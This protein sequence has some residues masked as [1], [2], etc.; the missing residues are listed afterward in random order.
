MKKRLA[1]LALIAL[2]LLSA[3]AAPQAAPAPA[4]ENMISFYYC[5][6]ELQ[7]G[8]QSGTISSEL[9]TIADE[10]DFAAWL[11]VYLRGPLSGELTTP[12]P[13]AVNVESVSL[14]GACATVVLSAEYGALVGIERTLANACLT[15]T[16]TQL[17]GVESVRIEVVDDAVGAPEVTAYTASDFAEFDY[18]SNAEEVT[19]RLY[20]SDRAHRYLLSTTAQVAAGFGDHLPD[21]IVSRLIAGPSDDAMRSVMPEGTQLLGCTIADGV[22]T[23]DFNQ[24]FYDNRPTAESVERVLIYSIVNSV[25]GLSGIHTVRFEIEG[26]PAGM[27]RYL[28]LSLAYT[29]NENAVG[30]VR[31]AAG[32]FD[33]TLY[34]CG[35]DSAH[36]SAVPLRVRCDEGQSQEEA[37]MLALLTIQ[38]PTGLSSPIPA[39]TQLRS[40][41]TADGLCQVDLSEEFRSVQSAAATHA[42]VLA[43]T[44]LPG[45]E[46]VQLLVEGE[47]R[48]SVLT[49]DS[50]WRYPES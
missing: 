28:D 31:E 47:T 27:Y 36:L 50:A 38:P 45:V 39:G 48:T 32:E 3:C 41:Q 35:A 8:A 33:G 42:I 49:P 9:R 16:L 40:V 15:R 30:P 17:D 21:Y 29:F 46:R 18:A 13:R 34:L 2:A 5:Q 25:T 20:Y 37:L 11:P 10:S 7:Y 23:L 6:T 12:F 22:C 19:L 4:T 1:V 14:N 44:D 24:A 26:E 43:L